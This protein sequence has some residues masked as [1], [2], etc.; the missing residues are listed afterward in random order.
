MMWSDYLCN[1]KNKAQHTQKSTVRTVKRKQGEGKEEIQAGRG[2]DPLGTEPLGFIHKHWF[3]HIQLFL[4]FYR[5]LNL[6][7]GISQF[8]EA[9][10]ILPH[11]RNQSPPCFASQMVRVSQTGHQS[12][13]VLIHMANSPCP[14]NS[15]CSTLLRNK[16]IPNTLFIQ[17]FFVIVVGLALN[18]LY[19]QL[20]LWFG[21]IF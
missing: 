2:N 19:P 20:F 3:T 12:R 16:M 7:R 6:V 18:N 8:Q 9:N 10:Q 5:Y 17:T 21:F 1:I 4:E 13:L 15:I 11:L 14:Q